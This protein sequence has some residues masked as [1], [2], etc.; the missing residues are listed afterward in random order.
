MADEAIVRSHLLDFESGEHNWR[1]KAEAYVLHQPG[2]VPL[3]LQLPFRVLSLTDKG[4]LYGKDK[5]SHKGQ[6][7]DSPVPDQLSPG[8][9]CCGLVPAFG[10]AATSTLPNPPD[11]L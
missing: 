9:P 7:E 11:S 5:H 10:P 3:N 8:P 6:S 2:A 4:C 1:R